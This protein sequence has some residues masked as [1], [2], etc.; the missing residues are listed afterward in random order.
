MRRPWRRSCTPT[1]WTIC[2]PG[3]SRLLRA[4]NSRSDNTYRSRLFGPG[5]SL[6]E[7][8]SMTAVTFLC[9]AGRTPAPACARIRKIRLA[10]GRPGRQVG[11]PGGQGRA[12][13]GQRCGPGRSSRWRLMQYGAQWRAAD[14]ERDR[15]AD[16]RPARRARPGRRRLPAIASRRP[17]PAAAGRSRWRPASASCWRVPRPPRGGQLPGVLRPVHEPEFQSRHVAQRAQDA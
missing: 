16:R 1:R 2:V 4:E 17:L 14:P 13:Q 7:M 6:A 11:V 5:R 8:E 15:S 10:G 3:C 12:A 9:R